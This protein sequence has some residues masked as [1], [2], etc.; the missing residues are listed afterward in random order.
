M[1]ARIAIQIIYHDP[2]GRRRPRPPSDRNGGRLRVGMTVDFRSETPAGIIGIHNVPA[3]RQYGGHRSGPPTS[4][5]SARPRSLVASFQTR[6]QQRRQLAPQIAPA[7]TGALH[8]AGTDT[9]QG[10]LALTM[11]TF[12]LIVT[13]AATTD[14]T[15]G[16]RTERIASFDDYQSC[17]SAG[18]A[19]YSQQHWECVPENQPQ[20]SPGRT[21]R[22]GAFRAARWPLIGQ[23]S[24]AIRLPG[25]G[26]RG[27]ASR[28]SA[29]RGRS[30]RHASQAVLR[31]PCTN[32][33]RL[34]ESPR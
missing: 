15:S 17:A 19:L 26:Y 2:R 34:H 22:P 11:K 3:L 5:I 24:E 18:R 9:V 30:E 12:V 25:A 14:L 31:Y 4:T 32:A 8:R 29:R 28:P 10:L 1:T 7:R 16:A 20:G 23:R 13:F 33:R 21:V 6:P 27:L